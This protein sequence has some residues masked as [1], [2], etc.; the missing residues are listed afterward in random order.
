MRF[1]D[2]ASIA[3]D[4]MVN[5]DILAGTDVSTGNDRKFTLANLAAWLLNKFNGLSLAGSNQT[6]KSALDSLNSNTYSLLIGTAITSGA[7]LDAY[8][9]A[10]NFYSASSTITNSLSNAPFNGYGFKMH[11]E[12]INSNG[13]ILQTIASGHT[14]SQHYERRG[15]RAS[16]AWTFSDWEEQ[17]TRAEMDALSEIYTGTTNFTS[18]DPIQPN[19]A[20]GLGAWLDAKV[21][22][23]ISTFSTGEVHLVAGANDSVAYGA[24]F[25]K[26]SDSY[27]AGIVWSYHNNARNTAWYFK[28]SNG[29]YKLRPLAKPIAD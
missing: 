24:S 10:G 9:T 25:Y 6:V 7:D 16:G 1:T 13:T 17:P 29:T 18:I 14:P 2:N 23:Q 11:V 19:N 26:A 21:H 12:Y 8:T 5:D 3:T 22:A 27:Y 28:Y 20:R 15:Q 4:T